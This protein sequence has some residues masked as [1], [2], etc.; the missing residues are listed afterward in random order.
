MSFINLIYIR[1]V[2][3]LILK[4]N[5]FQ[6][7][8][9]K[10]NKLDIIA[11]IKE[12]IVEKKH[13]LITGCSTGIGLYIAKELHA[14]KNYEVY[15][16]CRSQKD[17]DELQKQGIFSCKLDLDDSESIKSGL[18]KV[19]EKSGGKLDVLFNNGAYG[20]AGAV[21][22]LS[23]KALKDQF[24]TN[25]FGTI[26]LTNLVMKIFR[27]QNS[28]RVIFNSSVLGFAAMLYRG[29]YNASKYAIEGFADTMRQEVMGSGISV[30]LIEPGPIRSKFR[31]TAHKKFL[32]H[33]DM[34]NSFHKNTYVQALKR[35]ESKE[36]TPFTLGEDAVYEVFLKAIESENPK[37]R[38]MVTKP[39]FI[40]WYLKKI[41]PVWVLDKLLFKAGQ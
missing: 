15:A 2:C 4:I 14:N 17:V 26:E 6:K 29:A 24:Q 11:R 27:K 34:E 18:D 16:T 22:D 38:Y 19:L 36:D 20:Q 12:S 5:K 21:E 7:I 28:G 8:F 30:I 39:T 41:L 1:I 3:C 10:D 31:Q 33:I 35:L 37:A 23:Q 32:E 40:F 25:V 9:K 13:I